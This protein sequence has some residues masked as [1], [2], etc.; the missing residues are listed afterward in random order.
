[1]ISLNLLPEEQRKELLRVRRFWI[2]VRQSIYASAVF[3]FFIVILVSID[4]LLAIEL[5]TL[6]DVGAQ[7]QSQKS[8]QELQRYEEKFQ[9]IN[10]QTSYRLKL[11]KNHLFW[12]HVFAILDNVVPHGIT[13]AGFSTTDNAVTITGIAQQRDTL[14]AFKEQ[15]SAQECLRNVDIPLADLVV[16]E[17]VQFHMTFT[18]GE[19]CL[20][21]KTYQVL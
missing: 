1:M 8:Y 14:L 5:K 6:Q 16:R 20:K 21:R 17:D 12:S 13:L 11:E 9:S 4:V 18:V 19:E 15:L 3:L 10:A 7:Q 2:V